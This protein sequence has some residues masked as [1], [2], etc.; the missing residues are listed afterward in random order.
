MLHEVVLHGLL[1]VIKWGGIPITYI[2]EEGVG[3]QQIHSI[4]AN[5]LLLCYGYAIWM[6][7]LC[8]LYQYSIS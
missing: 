2:P 8:K 6:P 1:R 5:I 4:T 7:I 3:L